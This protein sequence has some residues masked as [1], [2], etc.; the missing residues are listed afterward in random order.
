MRFI[1]DF[2][3]GKQAVR[4]AF[5]EHRTQA[6][7]CMGSF[8]SIPPAFAAKKMGISIF[9]HDGNARL[10]KANKFLSRYAK[11]LA[12]SFPSPDAA[13]CRCPAILTGMPL[14]QELKE[15][16]HC[17]RE[18]AVKKINGIYGSSF[19]PSRPVLLAFGGSLGAASLNKAVLS[20]L[21][22]PG[23]ENLQIIHLAGK[24]KVKELEEAYNSFRGTKL[25]LES[26]DAMQFLYPAA[27]L[28]ISRAGG[29]TVAETACF[30]KYTILV[31]YPY[32]AED[33]QFDNASYLAESGGAVIIRDNET[34][35]DK[36]KKNISSFLASPEIFME[37]GRKNLAKAR[38][39]AAKEIIDMME[40]IL[41]AAQIAGKKGQ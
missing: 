15:C 25:L 35:A 13:K 8:A 28:I 38:P 32:A 21:T 30:G 2:F 17:S 4:N 20:L 34:L 24:G 19:I 10:G 37:N 9:L 1:F 29:S 36:L 16:I 11:A 5:R 40:N 31:P 22:L 18:E 6:L 14:R 12:L 23:A 39:D 26:S 27:D 7:L 41:F 3:A 33:H